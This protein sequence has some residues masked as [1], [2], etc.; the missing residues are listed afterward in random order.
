MGEKGSSVPPRK[1]DIEQRDAAAERV[2]GALAR[3]DLALKGFIRRAA[4][5]AEDP[6]DILQEVYVRLLKQERNEA[7]NDYPRAYLI[8]TATNII[9]D[10]RRR[11]LV[12]GRA[13]ADPV[14]A[15]SAGI[16]AADPQP[17]AEDAL[18]WREGVTIVEEALKSLQPKYVT[19]FILRWKEGLTF[20]EISQRTGIPTRSAERYA[21][22]ALAHCRRVLEKR[23]WRI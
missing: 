2:E 8:V 18:M 21:S 4:R 19:V 14:L 6:D 17:S 15:V 11:Q 20:Q 1:A 12:S 5:D 13:S 16:D 10:R 9:R 22:H 7:V 23:K 3:H